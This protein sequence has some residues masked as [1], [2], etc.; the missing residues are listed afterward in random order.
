MH[1][2]Q[3]QAYKE[4]QQNKGRD[5]WEMCHCATVHSSRSRAAVGN[6]HG[7]LCSGTCLRTGAAIPSL[8]G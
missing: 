5:K 8:I 6:N 1:S 3:V 7:D 4:R 2:E